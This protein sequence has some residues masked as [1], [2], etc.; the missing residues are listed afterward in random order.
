MAI[1]QVRKL[2][3]IGRCATAAAILLVWYLMLPPIDTATWRVDRDAPLSQWQ[4][5]GD[6]S[7]LA[8]C[9]AVRGQILTRQIPFQLSTMPQST[10]R[11]TKLDS[12][13]VAG[14]DPRLSPAPK[15]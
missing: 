8:E 14:H 1:R 12:Q 13:C 6:Y 2:T 15:L 3:T 11:Y 9:M 10:F 4:R 5:A 7:S